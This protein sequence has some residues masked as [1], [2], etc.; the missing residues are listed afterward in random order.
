MVSLALFRGF[1]VRTASGDAVHL[2][3]RKTQ[4]LLAYVAGLILRVEPEAKGP[5]TGTCRTPWTSCRPR[6]SIRPRNAIA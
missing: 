1:K 6:G 3:T 2:P 5:T 4:A